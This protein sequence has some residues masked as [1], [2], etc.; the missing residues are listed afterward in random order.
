MMLKV[1]NKRKFIR[2]G[3]LVTIFLI[4]NLGTAKIGTASFPAEFYL[5]ENF[6]WKIDNIS[7]G[8]TTWYNMS[9]PVCSWFAN[10]SDI[11]TYN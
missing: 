2:V 3:L 11:L 7:S 9:S 8:V 1:F 6:S 10:K 5:G 4:T